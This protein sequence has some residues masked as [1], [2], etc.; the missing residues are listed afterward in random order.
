LLITKLGKVIRFKTDK[1]RSLGR[2]T[3]GVRIINLEKEDQ[4]VS[5]AKVKVS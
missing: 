3:Q 1:F 2:A 5:M 4:V